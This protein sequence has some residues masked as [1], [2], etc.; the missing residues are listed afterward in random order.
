M[1]PPMSRFAPFWRWVHGEDKQ[2]VPGAAEFMQ[3][4]WELDIYPHLEM[5]EAV[6]FR[7]FKSWQQALEGELEERTDIV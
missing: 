2:A 3:V 6:P 7:A 5:C 4:L 1:R